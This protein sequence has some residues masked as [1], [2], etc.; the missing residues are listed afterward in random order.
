MHIVHKN[1]DLSVHGL[2]LEPTNT[3]E[4]TGSLFSTFIAGIQ[5]FAV[6]TDSKC[7]GNTTS[8][9]IVHTGTDVYNPY[10]KIPIH[11]TM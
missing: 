9:G 6:A 8:T 11:S 7:R 2:F 4:T 10:D 1:R 3:D 5:S